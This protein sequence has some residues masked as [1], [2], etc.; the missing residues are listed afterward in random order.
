MVSLER[1][2]ASSSRNVNPVYR[3]FFAASTAYLADVVLGARRP[4]YSPIFP[5]FGFEGTWQAVCLLS[6]ALDSF[7]LLRYTT[8]T[9]Q[10]YE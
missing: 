3:D 4:F 7:G 1:G 10:K 6:L 5:F 9:K 2:N 8:T